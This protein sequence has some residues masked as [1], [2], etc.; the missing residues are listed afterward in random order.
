MS[1]FKETFVGY[2]PYVLVQRIDP[3]GKLLHLDGTALTETDGGFP[4]D[5]DLDNQLY[6]AITVN[7]WVNNS[8]SDY[9]LLYSKRAPIGGS[10]YPDIWSLRVGLPVSQGG[11]AYLPFLKR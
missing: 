4:V 9:L 3:T 11:Y 5:P 8:R 6:I 2:R 10:R 1:I 7:P